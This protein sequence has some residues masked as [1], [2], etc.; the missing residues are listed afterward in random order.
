MMKAFVLALLTVWCM[1]AYDPAR[2]T[3]FGACALDESRLFSIESP[4]EAPSSGEA[5]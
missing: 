5:S 4:G 1:G 3:N 2:G